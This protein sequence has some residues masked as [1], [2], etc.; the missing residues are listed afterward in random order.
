MVDAEGLGCSG[1]GQ[2]RPQARRRGDG[3]QADALYTNAMAANRSNTRPR[4]VKTG[5]G[6]ASI[7]IMVVSL[8][9]AGKAWA[10]ADSK[11]QSNQPHAP[12]PTAVLLSR[13]PSVGPVRSWRFIAEPTTRHAKPRSSTFPFPASH[14][15]HGSRR[16]TDQI[17]TWCR[18]G[19]DMIPKRSE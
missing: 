16:A 5:D 17:L 19:A 12:R 8:E 2:A 10:G 1:G 11:I 3:S 4:R 14:S 15:V 6:A 13:R 7:E 18:Y 9:N